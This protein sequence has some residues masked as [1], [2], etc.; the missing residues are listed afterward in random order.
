MVKTNAASS[1]D[2][3]DFASIV[4]EIAKKTRLPKSKVKSVVKELVGVSA[5]G[6]KDGKKV[7]IAGLGTLRVRDAG[8]KAGGAKRI[9]LTAAK[10]LK[11][12]TEAG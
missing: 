6:L 5:A 3:V 4:E 1:A 9:V 11:A 7:R 12:A 10:P 8:E 2:M